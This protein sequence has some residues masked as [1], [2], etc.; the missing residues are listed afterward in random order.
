M[1]SKIQVIHSLKPIYL[2]KFLKKIKL[3]FF[4]FKHFLK[5]ALKV[6]IDFF[7]LLEDPTKQY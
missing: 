7:S 1:F 6:L 5:F 4:S 2:L 3:I